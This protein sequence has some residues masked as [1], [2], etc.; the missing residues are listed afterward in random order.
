[1]ICGFYLLTA[2]DE[3]EKAEKGRKGSGFDFVDTKG[4]YS[5]EGKGRRMQRAPWGFVLVMQEGRTRDSLSGG[6]KP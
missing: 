2:E 6:I 1:M 5:L 4:M 3:L